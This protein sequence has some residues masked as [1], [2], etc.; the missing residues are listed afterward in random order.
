M[1]IVLGRGGCN[2]EPGGNWQKPGT[3]QVSMTMLNSSAL[4]NKHYL[5]KFN[6][7]RPT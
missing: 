6:R 2:W 5:M 1:K 3:T 4:S 7:I